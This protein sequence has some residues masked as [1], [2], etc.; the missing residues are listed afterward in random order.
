MSTIKTEEKIRILSRATTRISCVSVVAVCTLVITRR[1][2][3]ETPLTRCSF[4]YT[5]TQVAESEVLHLTMQTA[6]T[7]ILAAASDLF[8]EI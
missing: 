2:K 7:D 6:R 1:M 5:H 4:A 3:G 8:M